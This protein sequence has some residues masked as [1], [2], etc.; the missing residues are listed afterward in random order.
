MQ[1]LKLI[2][3]IIP[4]YN[5]ERYLRRCLESILVQT[6]RNLEILLI[7]DGSTDNSGFIC[8]QYA[9]IDNRVRV[10]HIKNAGVSNAR[11]LGIE[12]ARGEYI[13]FVDA[14]DYIDFDMYEKLLEEAIRD[15]A[16]MVFCGFK[17]FETEG[18]FITEK[19]G[20]EDFVKEK[21]LSHF[22]VANFNK[23]IM[24]AVWR[25]LFKKVF[26]AKFHF[27]TS[28]V[29][30][31]D[32]LFVLEAAT[33]TSKI[34][35]ISDAP[36]NYFYQNS[37]NYLKYLKNNNY[38]KSQQLLTEK[39][40]YLLEKSNRID[41]VKYRR[42]ETYVTTLRTLLLADDYKSR[43]KD[44]KRNPFW[45]NLNS[46]TNYREYKKLNT[47]L[48]GSRKIGNFLIYNNL[49]FFYRLLLKIKG[50]ANG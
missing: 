36:Y 37:Q 41:L 8:D 17:R 5:C 1:G 29:L 11:N 47:T 13:G 9:E 21:D 4:I 2:S 35:C 44:I 24:G 45:A 31:E 12:K 34:S 22:I 40:V 28:I 39:I 26:V 15:D 46:K 20:I 10:F 14:D 3:I 6:Y 49:F 27:E 23:T 38:L 33:N 50:R 42:W 25:I 19:S 32:L 18:E 43:I 48:K 16:D 7:D 30:G